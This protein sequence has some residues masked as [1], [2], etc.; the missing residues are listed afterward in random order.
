MS[1]PRSCVGNNVWRQ[2][3]IA[4]LQESKSVRHSVVA[5][6]QVREVEQIET[7]IDRLDRGAE[8]VDGEETVEICDSD[9]V[10]QAAAVLGGCVLKVAVIDNISAGVDL[11]C[12]IS[13]ARCVVRVGEYRGSP[14]A[15]VEGVVNE[16]A[17][18]DRRRCQ[19]KK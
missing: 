2:I 7:E 19:Q 18:L 8:R 17:C 9:R 10:V 1:V 15:V 11:V 12:G 16:C 5:V 6:Q 3:S 14:I 4:S 13:V